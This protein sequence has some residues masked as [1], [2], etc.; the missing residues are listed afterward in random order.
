MTERQKYL[1]L[2]A[3][4][5]EELPTGSID[6]AV[7]AGYAASSMVLAN[8]RGGRAMNLTHL[9][10]LIRYGMPEYQVPAHLLPKVSTRNRVV[11]SSNA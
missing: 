8:V 2:L 3:D 5:I 6:I 11:D 7:R 9:V 4:V 10:A 1:Y